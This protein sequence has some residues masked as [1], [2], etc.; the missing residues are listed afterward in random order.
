MLP[1]DQRLEADDLAVDQVDL[2]LVIKKQLLPIERKAQV[3]FQREALF[4]PVRHFRREE[5]QAAAA[6]RLGLIQ[7]RIRVALQDFRFPAVRRVE[8]DAYV[9]AY[10]DA[11]ALEQ[12]GLGQRID[13]ALR[14]QVDPGHALVAA[15]DDAELVA[16]D[17]GHGIAFRH[18]CLQALAHLDQHLVAQMMSQAF[19]DDLEIVQIERQQGE[20]G[21][22]AVGV[23]DRMCQQFREQHTV[24]QAG[25]PVAMGEGAVFLFADFQHGGAL[26]NQ[27]F[28]EAAQAGQFQMGADARPHLVDV[29]GLGNVIGGAQLEAQHLLLGGADDRDEDDGNAVASRGR[30]DAA[31]HLVTV[32][33][34]HDDIQQH[35][36]GRRRTVHY[37]ECLEAGTGHH[38]AVLALQ[39][40]EQFVNVCRHVIDHQQRRRMRRI[41]V[42]RDV[43]HHG[44][45]PKAL[46]F[47][48]ILHPHLQQVR[49]DRLG[50]V[51]G[52]ALGEA[53]CLVGRLRQG[54]DEDHR[55]L[56][57]GRVDLEGGQHGI[58]VHLRHLDVEQDQ[59]GPWL[60]A[61]QFESLLAAGG[62]RDGIVVAQDAHQRMQVLGHVVDDQDPRA[63]VR[64]FIRLGAGNFVHEVLAGSEASSLCNCAS[65]ASISKSSTSNA[66]AATSASSGVPATA[67][68]SLA[69][70]GSAAPRSYFSACS[71]S[72]SSS[73]KAAG[74]SGVEAA[75]PG[76]G[77]AAMPSISC[78]A[79]AHA[80]STSSS[81]TSSGT[82]PCLSRLSMAVIFPYSAWAPR[83]PVTPF[84]A[85]QCASARP[86][87]FSASRR[88][89]SAMAP[90]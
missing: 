70:A 86:R 2:G 28:E 89:S 49:I 34:R 1:P 36:I 72:A 8:R 21:A 81:A 82:C 27:V 73:R 17:A 76:A 77:A 26:R 15:E 11:A 14:P 75:R 32:H 10:I 7:G 43:E 84:R 35:Q 88:R 51:I 66:M 60:A 13:H 24:G 64:L 71:S 48:L 80:A 56:G 87:S 65:A 4:G 46:Q 38:D 39:G 61:R 68:P 55:Y 18:Q 22:V 45:L 30:L 3:A 41:G 69:S 47:E 79:C 74:V 85:W 53:A 78:I 29:E 63:V 62:G 50:D 59:V 31:A 40:L 83:L 57:R 33:L 37:F 58:A 90:R 52:D 5:L 25:E 44:A 9:D 16:A 54:G 67:L 6:L 42:G 12:E 20:L 23:Q 19:V